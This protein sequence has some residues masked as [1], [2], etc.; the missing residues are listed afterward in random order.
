MINKARKTS[1]KDAANKPAANAA[2]AKSIA[3]KDNATDKPKK[4]NN[5]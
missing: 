2:D 3:K 1:A 5:K 4:E